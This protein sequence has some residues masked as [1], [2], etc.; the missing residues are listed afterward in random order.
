MAPVD[1]AQTTIKPEETTASEDEGKLVSITSGLKSRLVIIPVSED[2]EVID[3]TTEEI[4]TTDGQTTLAENDMVKDGWE[5][6]TAGQFGTV[7]SRNQ[8]F[9]KLSIYKSRVFGRIKTQSLR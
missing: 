3:Q 1:E 6:T 4:V 9:E 5:A 7:F 8:K 2:A